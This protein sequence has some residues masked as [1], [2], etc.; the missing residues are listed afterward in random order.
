MSFGGGAQK[1]FQIGEITAVENKKGLKVCVGGYFGVEVCS[2]V[3]ALWISIAED[4]EIGVGRCGDRAIP[5]QRKKQ[6]CSSDMR[7]TAK[8]TDTIRLPGYFFPRDIG[9]CRSAVTLP[10]KPNLAPTP[11]IGP[12][13]LAFS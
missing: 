5:V 13:P 6:L 2:E 10:Q 4:F 1:P 3:A 11:A 8:E 7:E 12:F 9:M